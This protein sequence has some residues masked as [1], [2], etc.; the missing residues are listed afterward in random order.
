MCDAH[1]QVCAQH[2]QCHSSRRPSQ[3]PEGSQRIAPACML[4]L[5]AAPWEQMSGVIGIGHQNM[6]LSHRACHPE[7]RHGGQGV[8]RVGPLSLGGYY[9]RM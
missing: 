4:P 5:L 9:R 7:P 1:R 6:V 2:A 3:H 8:G